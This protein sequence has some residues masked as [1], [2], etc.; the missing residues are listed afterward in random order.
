MEEKLVE[1]ELLVYESKQEATDT[2]K[3]LLDPKN[4]ESS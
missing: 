1:E 4:D 3:T 2:L